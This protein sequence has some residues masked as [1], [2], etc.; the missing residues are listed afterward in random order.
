MSDLDYVELEMAANALE[1][2]LRDGG[3]AFI[4]RDLILAAFLAIATRA[5]EQAAWPGVSN[6]LHVKPIRA[7]GHPPVPLSKVLAALEKPQESA[8]EKP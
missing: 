5:F 2:Q 7:L 6:D 1:C 4:D 3:A 8:K